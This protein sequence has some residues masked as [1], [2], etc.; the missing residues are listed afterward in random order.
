MK[1]W[2]SEK[3]DEGGR[4]IDVEMLMLKFRELQTETQRIMSEVVYEQDKWFRITCV[5]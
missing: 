1:L 2:L 4:A 5:S 3:R